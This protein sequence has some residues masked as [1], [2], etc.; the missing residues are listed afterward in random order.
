MNKAAT[1]STLSSM[2]N[3]SHPNH[4]LSINITGIL[5]EYGYEFTGV[6]ILF[7]NT[8]TCP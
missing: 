8:T 6:C 1:I 2:L 7:Q 4:F 5:P 3:C